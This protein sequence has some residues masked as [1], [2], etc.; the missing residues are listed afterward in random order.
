MRWFSV[1][2]FLEVSNQTVINLSAAYFAVAFVS[3]GIFGIP[4]S[5][6]FELLLKN[7]PFG[8]LGLIFCSWLA[9]RIKIL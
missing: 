3:P 9:E 5:Q 6:Y 8:I 7:I 1:K 2:T 4:S